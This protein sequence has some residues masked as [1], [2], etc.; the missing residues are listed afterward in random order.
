MGSNMVT[1]RIGLASVDEVDD[2]VETWLRQAY[3]ENA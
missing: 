2:E 3:A 1:L